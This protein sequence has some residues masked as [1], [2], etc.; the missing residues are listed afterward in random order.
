M[1]T[2]E[3]PSDHT[4]SNIATAVEETL[5]DWNIDTVKVVAVVTDNAKNM[6]NAVTELDMFSFPCIGHTL[7]LGV[8]KAF[9]I[10]KVHTALARVR[11][12]V[13]Y[14][15][16]S[17][18]A[19][20]KLREKQKLLGLPGHHLINDCIMKW[21]STYEMLEILSAATSYLCYATG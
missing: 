12:L 20:Y 6:T 8:K 16:R 19:M 1:S 21:G 10:P 4:A 13:L 7:Q 15:H 5:C 2:K 17:P 14:F 18:K 3:L 9:D 11:R